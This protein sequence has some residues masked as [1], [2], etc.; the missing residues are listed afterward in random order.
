MVNNLFFN[1]KENYPIEKFREKIVDAYNKYDKIRMIFDL[2]GVKITSTMAMYKIKK[3]FKE[4]GVE[5]LLE[6]CIIP[7]SDFQARV[8]KGFL[9]SFETERD[10]RFLTDKPILK[11]ME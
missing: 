6:T 3:V 8:V 2:K 9:S 4:L 11:Y 7:E 1:I 5:K 10:V